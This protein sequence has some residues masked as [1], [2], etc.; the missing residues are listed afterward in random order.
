MVIIQ[1]ETNINAP[2]EPVKEM[3]LFV[4]FH[5]YSEWGKI[6]GV[7]KA[8]DVNEAIQNKKIF[9]LIKIAEGLHE[10]KIAQIAD[11][12]AQKNLSEVPSAEP[13]SISTTNA[14]P[15]N[16]PMKIAKPTVATADNPVVEV[17]D[18]KRDTMPSADFSDI[19]SMNATQ[20]ED[21]IDALEVKQI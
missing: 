15:F 9:P 4:V 14:I 5:E 11:M 7:K 6:L 16:E 1:P 10:K 8:A 3:N 13:T 18:E 2:I 20:L 21:Y 19:E 17:L 12:L